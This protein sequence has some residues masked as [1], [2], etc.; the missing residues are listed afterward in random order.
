[1]NAKALPIGRAV[2]RF[3]GIFILGHANEH[4]EAEK[5]CFREFC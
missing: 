4:K 2:S 3:V 5:R 1:M